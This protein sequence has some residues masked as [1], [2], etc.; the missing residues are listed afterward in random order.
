MEMLVEL[1]LRLF[2][3]ASDD[4]RL[5]ESYAIL[6]TFFSHINPSLDQKLLNSLSL[7]SKDK[8]NLQG[9]CTSHNRMRTLGVI[10]L[11]NNM[12][13][14]S[15]YFFYKPRKEAKKIKFLNYFDCCKKL[16][17]IKLNRRKIQVENELRKSKI[18]KVI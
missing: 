13:K 7:F 1:F 14:S 8:K 17:S 12:P 4:R 2:K 9:I 18:S 6:M 11:S 15:S 5:I 3:E 16:A 10:F